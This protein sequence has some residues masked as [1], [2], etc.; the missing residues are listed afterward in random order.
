LVVVLES[1]SARASGVCCGREV[2]AKHR[3]T[4]VNDIDTPRPDTISPIREGIALQEA[5]RLARDREP[6][7]GALQ[8][9]VVE[10]IECAR[11]DR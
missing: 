11:V 10:Q 8:K 1:R 9:S 6:G 3:Q 2:G 5:E 7:D 4:G